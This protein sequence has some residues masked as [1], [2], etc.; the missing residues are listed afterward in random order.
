MK[1]LIVLFMLGL[2]HVANSFG[3]V[4]CDA[5]NYLVFD[6]TNGIY[7]ATTPY[8]TTTVSRSL[9]SSTSATGWQVSAARPAIVHYSIMVQTTATIVGGQRG[10]VVVEIAPTNSTTP[11]DWV[12]VAGLINGQALSLALTLQSIQPIGADLLAFVP[13]GYY[14]R[15]RQISTTGAPTFSYMYG[16]EMPI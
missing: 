11:S 5:P 8:V 1:A 9:V 7:C 2:M 3:M 6:A 13:A 15:I 16:Q 4:D 12:V 14:I 10:D